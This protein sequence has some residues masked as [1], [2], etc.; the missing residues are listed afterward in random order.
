MT[1]LAEAARATR[2]YFVSWHGLIKAKVWGVYPQDLFDPYSGELVAEIDHLSSED[3]AQ[4]AC[5]RLNLIAVLEALREPSEG[6]VDSGDAVAAY[7]GVIEV[8][9]AMIDAAIAEVRQ[10]L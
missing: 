10:K 2:K 8:W 1:D 9:S 4:A 6:V 7:G 3:E 5:D